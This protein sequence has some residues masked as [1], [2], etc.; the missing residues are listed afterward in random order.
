MLFSIASNYV[1]T[2][3]LVAYVNHPKAL[4]KMIIVVIVK[5]RISRR[6]EGAFG[7]GRIEPWPLV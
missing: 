7:V 1:P 6:L 5:N 3:P 4:P 2:H